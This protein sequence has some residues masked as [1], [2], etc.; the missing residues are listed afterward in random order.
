MEPTQYRIY[1]VVPQGRPSREGGNP[2]N[3]ERLPIWSWIPAFAGRTWKWKCYSASI[4]IRAIP[5]GIRP[6]NTLG[7]QGRST[8]KSGKEELFA[9]LGYNCTRGLNEAAAEE[10]LA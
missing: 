8:K 3:P 4:P 7:A 9:Q 5:A 1:I 10:T 6:L 2:A